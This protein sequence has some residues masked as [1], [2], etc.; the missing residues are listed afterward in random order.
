M[1]M[2][3][4]SLL[5][6]LLLSFLYYKNTQSSMERQLQ[7]AN[8]ESLRQTANAIELVINQIGD[9]FRQ[10]V[11]DSTYLDYA[12]FPQGNYYEALTGEFKTEDLPTL[13]KYL[14]IKAKMLW[15]LD[16][17][18]MSNEYIYSVYM[19]DPSKNLMLTSGSMRYAADRFY[20][21][22]WSKGLDEE[23]FAYPIIM[24]IRYATQPDGKLRQVIPL[25]FRSAEASNDV[26]IN[27]DAE[28]L[29]A[30]IVKKLDSADGNELLILSKHGQTMVYGQAAG[31]EAVLDRLATGGGGEQSVEWTS[32]GRKLLAVQAVSSVMD[33]RFVRVTDLNVLY[34]SIYALRSI[35]VTIG[36]LLLAATALLAFLT[37][38][39]LYTPV[40][41]LLQFATHQHTSPSSPA[42]KHGE[43]EAIRSTLVEAFENKK[44][45]ELRLT[46]SLPAYKEKFIRSLFGGE[47][48]AL[49]EMN[50]RM[51]F[52]GIRFEPEGMMLLIV[53][54]NTSKGIPD[55]KQRNMN[56]LLVADAIEQVVTQEWNRSCLLA[57][58]TEDRYA[59]AVNVREEEFSDICA[60]GESVRRRIA[61]QTGLPCS[62][63][64]GRYCRRVEELKRA[65]EEAYEA[66]AY[67]DVT[68]QGD[69]IYIG[70]I[71]PAGAGRTAGLFAK[72]KEAVLQ[73]Y[74]RSGDSVKAA[75]V[76]R[77]MVAEIVQGQEGKASLRQMQHAFI[78]LLSGLMETAAELH[79][80][81]QAALEAK[82]FLYAE[83]LQKNDPDEI[84]NWF[85]RIVTVLVAYVGEA[86]QEKTDR[87]I[88]DAIRIIE[89][90]YGDN[91][92]LSMVAE[93]LQLNPSY[94]SRIFKEKVGQNFLAYV[95]SMRLEK[96]KLLLMQSDLKIKDISEQL[97]Y[98]KV[99]YFIKLFREAT[100]ITPNEYRKM[101][102]QP[103]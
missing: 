69:V 17:L 16:S 6:L 99:N 34:T 100:G 82:Q 20:D 21:P 19:S 47:V 27:L 88:R 24:G 85:E 64:I 45:L 26:V 44:T 13:Q 62:I 91:I 77:Q 71:R 90:H 63:G 60:M 59:F 43:L 80:D 56:K 18:K 7:S 57:E 75:A 52:L 79:L 73:H 31:M 40:R 12:T 4:V 101:H 50:E 54:A 66:L 28:A 78:Q 84:A 9:S 10:F 38:R 103:S 5:P 2:L 15:N 58:M 95:T 72:D 23:Q 37:T 87:H 65:C 14:S 94:L 68:G 22:G 89:Q 86:Y 74:I 8:I 49:Q 36:S 1:Y 55:M 53:L 42:K 98:I 46:E 93:R 67:R 102:N 39:T 70:D 81:L 48:P 83:L 61:Q 92:S 76:L 30:K 33:W 29:F 32:G 96:S 25:V 3:I 35:M 41:R 11:N 97:G 51:R